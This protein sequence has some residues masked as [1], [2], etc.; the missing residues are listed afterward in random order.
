MVR[1]RRWVGTPKLPSAAYGVATHAF[2]QALMLVQAHAHAHVCVEPA[3]AHTR[4]PALECRWFWP[5]SCYALRDDA[6]V[7]CPWDRSRYI[8][9]CVCDGRY[10]RRGS[11]GLSP[12]QRLSEAITV[13]IDAHLSVIAK[14][15][16]LR[17][18]EIAPDLL[19]R[20]ASSGNGDAIWW[21]LMDAED[22]GALD[23]PTIVRTCDIDQCG[24]LHL[25]A[26]HGFFANIFEA[27]V[28]VDDALKEHKEGGSKRYRRLANSMWLYEANARTRIVIDEG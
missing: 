24:L 21:L 15:L 28:E 12:H 16:D 4:Q 1:G 9:T 17:V 19:R 7:L 8:R 22:G 3:C 11:D 13:C 18:S 26:K 23:G 14:E 2:A 20:A 25:A 5:Y 6:H 10:G 27:L